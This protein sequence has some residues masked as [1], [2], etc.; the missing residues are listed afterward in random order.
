MRIK[1]IRAACVDLASHP[2]TPPR[3]SASSADATAGA[4]SAIRSTA[5]PA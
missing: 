5:T 3:V 4:A 2:A 1:Q